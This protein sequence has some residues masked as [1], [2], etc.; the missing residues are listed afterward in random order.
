[1][2]VQNRELLQIAAGNQ[3]PTSPL[4]NSIAQDALSAF[5]SALESKDEF[6]RDHS[7]RV[8]EL[9]ARIAIQIKPRD[10]PFQTEVRLGGLL[11]DIGK[12]G[13]RESV[14]NKP[15]ALTPKEFAEVQ[16]HPI[17][18]ETILKPVVANP[19]ILDIVRSHHERWDGGGYPDALAKQS[20][21]LGARIVA[22]ADSYDAMT[23]ARPYRVGMTPERSL[24]ILR[25]GSGIQWDRA[26]VQAFAALVAAGQL[27]ER[28]RH[29]GRRERSLPNSSDV[30]LPA[31]QFLRYAA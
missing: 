7:S 9:A 12:I 26:V 1:M 4:A 28:S 19:S 20:I 10:I 24:E 30:H 5:I 31:D 21:P 15:G 8:S 17:I 22:V 23:S 25:E 16:R 27:P 13:I 2:E 14:I 18:G 6:T 29:S 3:V 11:H